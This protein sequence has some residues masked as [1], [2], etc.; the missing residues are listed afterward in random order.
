M[1]PEK[2]ELCGLDPAS[3]HRADRLQ[4]NTNPQVVNILKGGI[5]YSN[6]VVIMP[7]SPSE[8]SILHRKSIPGLEPTLAVHKEKLCFAPFGL[9][10]SKWDPST[11]VYLPENYSAEDLRGKSTCKVELQRQL[12][13]VEDASTIIRYQMLILRA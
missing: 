13:L 3:L 9:D 2:L 4:D 7:S 12:G 10:N 8:G 5:V 11:D 1:P 6:K